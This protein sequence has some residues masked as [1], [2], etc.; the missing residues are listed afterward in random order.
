M[1]ENK[2]QK[3]GRV[4]K[5]VGDFI[6]KKLGRFLGMATGII[7]PLI[8]AVILN[9]YAENW[10][11]VRAF[12][13]IIIVVSSAFAFALIISIVLHIREKNRAHNNSKKEEEEKKC[14][15]YEVGDAKKEIPFSEILEWLLDFHKEH[16]EEEKCYK[17][18]IGEPP[19]KRIPFLMEKNWLKTPRQKM[20]FAELAEDG[21]VEDIFKLKEG[22]KIK[23]VFDGQEHHPL[24]DG[25]ESTIYKWR[26]E[27]KPDSFDDLP[28][29]FVS[30]VQDGN[31]EDDLVNL[32][33]KKTTY[34]PISHSYIKMQKEAIEEAVKEGE[35]KSPIREDNF[36]ALH[37]GKGSLIR[38]K[39]VNLRPIAI[40][41]TAAVA[42]KTKT[43][44]GT[45]E[46][47]VAI[48]KKK[49]NMP[50]CAEEQALVPS[51]QLTVPCKNGEIIKNLQD[52]DLIKYNLL[53]GL[54]KE[55]FRDEHR[56]CKK[57]PFEFAKSKKF[58]DLYASF[59]D[60]DDKKRTDIYLL[61]FGLN[62]FNG[63]IDLVFSIIVNGPE[64]SKETEER[65]WKFF[66][67][68]EYIKFEKII[69]PKI[70]GWL[71]KGELHHPSAF[72]ISETLKILKE[73]ESKKT[74]D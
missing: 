14:S 62:S 66:R 39:K 18:Q 13:I 21:N 15:K 71:T 34:F 64:C 55:L 41:A 73:K 57:N 50:I 42:V 11:P 32:H 24:I 63:V 12:T 1:A 48:H 7:L 45:Y 29:L 68:G 67:D 52:Y 74:S 8:G 5:Y 53:R 17:C 27:R 43:K 23:L 30:E 54:S 69:D 70:E 38:N 3:A 19:F 4:L 6:I 51:V 25:M 10:G 26:G 40:G 65:V 49:D 58:Q 16:G 61:G 59:T 33:V 2:R 31:L 37:G 28:A 72:A 56:E 46:W 20:K 36:S 35:R 47:E 9:R 60:Q 22:G 44:D